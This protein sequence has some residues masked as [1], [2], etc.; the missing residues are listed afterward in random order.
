MKNVIRF[1]SVIVA[2]GVS[3]SLFAQKQTV[4]EQVIVQTVDTLF[5]SVSS[6]KV[7]GSFAQVVI[8]NSTNKSLGLKAKLT[9]NEKVPGFSLTH[10]LNAGTLEIT[11]NYPSNNWVSH[12]G[13]LQL[14]VPRGVSVDIINSS[15]YVDLNNIS[16]LKLTALTT[17]G[18]IKLIDS[19]GDFAL[20]STSGDITIQKCVGA[21]TVTSSSG[22]IIMNNTEG[23]L[24]LT[25]LSGDISIIQHQGSIVTE[26][27][28]GKQ[29]LETITGDITAK[30]ASALIK[31]SKAVGN[32]NLKSFSGT[33]SLFDIKGM[34]YSDSGAGDQT[35]AQIT[36]NG[37]SKF[38]STEGSIKMRIVNP[39]TEV[40]FKLLSEEG[41]IQ[42]RGNSKKKKL[43]LG[44]GALLIES[45]STTGGQVFN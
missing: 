7:N 32:L 33:I 9:A 10:K 25:N 31:I 14:T 35:G 11:I 2:L 8:V 44:K 45:F 3:I 28:S 34:I 39:T 37:N 29:T 13:E 1:F 42:A 23:P 40:T 6:L 21:L 38:V 22:K 36:L 30:S 19:K 12:S 4:Q 27:T 15:G 41:F 20:R 24:N 16:D 5:E 18:K 17:S 43:N 26:S